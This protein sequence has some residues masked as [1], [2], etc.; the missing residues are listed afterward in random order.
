[1]NGCSVEEA[2]NHTE[3]SGSL[4]KPVA[5]ILPQEGKSFADPVEHEY[6]LSMMIIIP[7]SLGNHLKTTYHTTLNFLTY[8]F[9]F[10]P[11]QYSNSVSH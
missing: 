10:L 11:P 5:R 6:I 1:M 2:L 3:E 7:Y 8:R 4:S 9:V